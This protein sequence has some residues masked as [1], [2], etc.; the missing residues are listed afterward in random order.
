MI[1]A[2]RRPTL[3][4]VG[5]GM[6]GGQARRGGP[7]PAP[8]I[9]SSIRM[10]GAEPHGTYN[11]ILLSQRPRRLQPIPTQLW[12]NPLEWYEERGVFVHAGVKAE[13]IDRDRARRRRRRR[14]G[15]RAVRHP[16]P[17]HR[18]A[19]V[20][21]AA[22]RASSSRGVFVFRTLDDCA[23]IAA[24]AQ[25]CDRAVVLGGGLLGLEAARGLLSHGLEVTVVEVA[26][27]LMPQQLDAAAGDL[28]QRKLEAMGVRVLL[29]AKTH[30][31]ARRRPR[32][33]RAL[34]GRHARSTPTWSSSVAASGP[35]SR[36]RRAAG[37]HVERGHRRRRSA[38]HQ[39]PGHLR[40][41]R[42]RP[43]SRP[44]STAWSIRST[45]R[46]ACWPTC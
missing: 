1:Q 23:T 38:A 2:R 17:G 32:Q 24:Y 5:T 37:L 31:A 14:Q 21:A 4:V 27:H 6:A 18:L 25:D 12:L 39:R 15:R 16:R 46:P 36:R 20:R 10:F 45:S 43:A 30:A 42:M 13:T 7:A 19:A 41:R 40:R 44:A 35:T 3:V 28:L 9:A 33:R 22:S 26:P 8:R 11:R 34:R 29:G